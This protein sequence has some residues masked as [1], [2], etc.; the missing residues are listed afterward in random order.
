MSKE[1]GYHWQPI[2]DFEVSPESL[3]VSELPPFIAVWKESRGDL[4]DN[5]YADFN[6][7]LQREWAIETGLIERLYTLDRGVTESL[8]ERG[9]VAA[10]INRNG[11]AQNPDQVVKIIRS[12]QD[13]MEGLFSFIK[14][15]RELS[16]GYIKELHAEITKHQK[17]TQAIDSL[18]QSVEIPLLRGEYKDL[19]NNPTRPDGRIHEYCPPVQVASEMDRL[20]DLHMGH[21]ECSPEVQAAWLHHRFVQIHPFQDGNGRVARCLATLVFIKAGLFPLVISYTK[22]QRNE[23]FD[24]L[25]EAD[26]GDLKS[27][28]RVFSAS[29]KRS[30]SQALGISQQLMK[31]RRTDQ[32]IDAAADFLDDRDRNLREEWKK[33][34]GIAE[35]LRSIAKERFEEVSERLLD[36]IPGRLAPK[37]RPDE[38][39]DDGKRSYYFRREIVKTAQHLGYFANLREYRPWIRLVIQMESQAEILLSFHGIGYE[40]RGAL[41]VSACFFCR[42]QTEE[43]EREVTDFEPLSSEIFP[44]SYREN[45]EEAGERFRDWL[46]DVLAKGLE[47]WR[48]GL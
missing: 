2:R 34:K 40:Y 26:Y 43:G 13:A 45:R 16:T 32:V 25:E 14:G 23:Y 7:K 42:V 9:I 28:I 12:H 4:N 17:T 6:A 47:I 22:G 44:I 21:A 30:I 3:E 48:T 11:G 33:A 36:K 5:E 15:D 24:A 37:F 46:E 31:R 19:S 35:Y 20:L 18:G 8:I 1:I 29:Q 41:A 39:P 27:L 38:E 10:L